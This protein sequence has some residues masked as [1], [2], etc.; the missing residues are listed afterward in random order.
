MMKLERGRIAVKKSAIQGWGVFAEQDFFPGDLVE[1]CHYISI[2]KRYNT[3]MNYSFG[4]RMKDSRSEVDNDY[5]AL[6]LGFGS[7]Y[8][9]SDSPHV[10]YIFDF[11]RNI[12]NFYATRPIMCGEEIFIDYGETWFSS[13]GVEA[14][15]ITSSAP[16]TMRYRI[17]KIFRDYK[18]ILRMIV[19]AAALTTSIS[20]LQNF[21]RLAL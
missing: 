17:K 10:T 2:E 6:I 20:L 11:T 7:I 16:I 1:A 15:N 4:F 12:V 18:I 14:I 21:Y 19:V 5:S 9:H 13:R 8:N 3:F